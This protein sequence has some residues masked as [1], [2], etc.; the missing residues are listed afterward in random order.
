MLSAPKTLLAPQSIPMSG[1]RPKLS[2]SSHP[3]TGTLTPQQKL[4]KKIHQRQLKQQTRRP[5]LSPPASTSNHA[6]F[7]DDCG[8]DDELDEQDDSFRSGSLATFMVEKHERRQF[9][10]AFVTEIGDLKKAI[11]FRELVDVIICAGKDTTLDEL[12]ALWPFDTGKAEI[13]YEEGFHVFQKV[14]GPEVTQ[15]AYERLIER[16]EVNYK[17]L[18][19]T[20][21]KGEM[22]AADKEELVK[23]LGRWKNKKL[24]MKEL[25][26][27]INTIRQELQNVNEEIVK[28]QRF[29]DSVMLPLNSSTE[30][31]SSVFSNTRIPPGDPQPQLPTLASTQSS[32]REK[33]VEKITLKSLLIQKNPELVNSIGYSFYVPRAVQISVGFRINEQIDSD[34]NRFQNSLVGYV[35][36]ETSP[37]QIRTDWMQYPPGLYTFCVRFI[38]PLKVTDPQNDALIMDERN[39]LTKEFK[40]MLMNTFDMFDFDDDGLLCKE[41]V[42]TYRIL[43]GLGPI[44]SDDWGKVKGLYQTRNDGLTINGFI[45]MHQI[46]ASTYNDRQKA[47]MWLR[48]RQLGYNRKCHLSTACPIWIDFQLGDGYIQMENF[49]ISHFTPESDWRLHDFYWTN[50]QPLPY[51]KEVATLR[52]FKAD[53]FACVIASNE[54]K[55]LHYKLDLSASNN[56]NIDCEDCVIDVKVKAN[57]MKILAVAIAQADAWFLCVKKIS[58]APVE[59]RPKP[60]SATPS[61]DSGMKDLR[62]AQMKS[63]GMKTFAI[64][65]PKFEFN[66]F[67]GAVEKN[68]KKNVTLIVG[69]CKLGL[70]ISADHGL[71]RATFL[72]NDNNS[73]D[74]KVTRVDL[75]A[76]P[77]RLTVGEHQVDC[78]CQFTEMDNMKHISLLLEGD[79]PNGFAVE[80]Y[81]AKLVRKGN[82]TIKNSDTIIHGPSLFVIFFALLL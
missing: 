24:K 50:G 52:M 57:E 2:T 49:E 23:L 32:Y 4:H 77:S 19:Q 70:L 7:V 39:Q 68:E 51:M 71:A 59:R 63:V 31:L 21:E 62:R 30:S 45:K 27:E 42:E 64:P 36:A 65:S 47:D 72:I 20:V 46:E 41:E 10:N 26:V 61:N 54:E 40:V 56:V 44:T 28:K 33:R 78:K 75:T 69:G 43:S 22:S 1:R 14:A 18:I 16:N 73:V 79:L 60:S 80:T 13:T 8:D 12:T 58:I 6:I 76:E 17:K 53:H 67:F 29:E 38:R 55:A 82:E 34:L 35:T 3:T 15:A 37:V 11:S 25:M 9:L 48:L 5:F 66:I 74:S 81:S